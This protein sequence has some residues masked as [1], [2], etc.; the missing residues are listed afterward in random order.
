MLK[1]SKRKGIYQGCFVKWK[2]ESI[3]HQWAMFVKCAPEMSK[4]HSEV[5]NA[6]R[7]GFNMTTLKWNH[8]AFN[9]D[10]GVHYIPLPLALAAESMIMDQL[11]TGQ[12][13]TFGYARKLFVDMVKLWNEHI[14][15]IRSQMQGVLDSYP[16]DEENHIK[17][18]MNILKVCNISHH[19]AALKSLG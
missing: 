3:K 17:E 6:I 7:R 8:G 19:P 16:D 2:K 9:E 4:K 10:E 15:D 14:I 12:E 1:H 18:V 11:A 5:P 13:V